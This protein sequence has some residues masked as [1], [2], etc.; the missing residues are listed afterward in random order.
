MIK[1][2][3]LSEVSCWH[4]G[5]EGDGGGPGLTFQELHT[6]EPSSS[7]LPSGGCRSPRPSALLGMETH[8]R[9]TMG[10]AQG[11]LRLQGTEDSKGFFFLPLK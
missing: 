3:A 5:C 10:K 8:L 2:M 9:E 1:Q 11:T 4:E 7:C 6:Q